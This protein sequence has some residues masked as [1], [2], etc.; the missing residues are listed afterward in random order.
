[1][2]SLGASPAGAYPCGEPR[3]SRTLSV[4]A[5]EECPRPA[6]ATRPRRQADF[7]SLAVFVGMLA[8]V[9]VVPVRY[10]RRRFDDPE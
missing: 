7:A 3:P 4:V 5:K 6:P 2:L 9:L 10:S 1:M 8:L